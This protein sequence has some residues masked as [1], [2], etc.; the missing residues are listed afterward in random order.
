MLRVVLCDVG[1]ILLAVVWLFRMAVV[2]FFET[3]DVEL[4]FIDLYRFSPPPG[5]RVRRDGS[6]FTISGED[7]ET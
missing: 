1:Q 2:A 7:P 4:Y 6:R 3:T 5:S